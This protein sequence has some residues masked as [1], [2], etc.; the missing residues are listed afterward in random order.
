L[1]PWI[2]DDGR[3]PRHPWRPPL[4][5]ALMARP[6]LLTKPAGV[7]AQLLGAVLVLGGLAALNAGA[8]G[9]GIVLIVASVGLFWLG[10]QTGPREDGP[11][12]GGR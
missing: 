12:G 8:Y 4:S 3:P 6:P 5:G 1:R 9:L 10:R 11:R 7:F 2:A